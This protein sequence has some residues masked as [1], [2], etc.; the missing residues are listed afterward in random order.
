MKKFKSALETHSRGAAAIHPL[1]KLHFHPKPR[2]QRPFLDPRPHVLPQD[3]STDSR[4][5]LPKS[6]SSSSLVIVERWR[7]I[8]SINLRGSDVPVPSAADSFYSLTEQNPEGS[9]S[10]LSASDA[11]C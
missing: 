11:C 4:L 7:E 5:A 2:E 6:G 8:K 3:N 1:P 9:E 10:P